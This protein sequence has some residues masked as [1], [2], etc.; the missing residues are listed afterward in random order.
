MK[1]MI[2]N[3]LLLALSL[4]LLTGCWNSREL[5]ELAIAVALG[6]DKTDHNHYVVS[7]Q[8]VNPGEISTKGGG[9][10]NRSPVSTFR[11]EGRSVFEALR[12]MTT[13]LNRKIYL[14]HLRLIV[15]G[16]DLAKEGIMV[17]MDFLSR[18]HEVRTDF[19][20]VVAK[21]TKAED[22]LEILTP[23][24]KIPASKLFSSLEMSEKNWAGTTKLTLDMLIEDL[25]SDG[26]SPV[27][28]GLFVS[29]PISKGK[30][31]ENT[32]FSEVPTVLQYDG[33]ALF[34]RDK[35]IGWLNETQT[36]GYNYAKGNV[37]STVG[38]LECPGGLAEIELIQTTSKIK[39][40]LTGG[41]NPKIEIEVHAEGNVGD[42]SCDMDMSD[43]ATI[44]KFEQLAADQI[45]ESINNAIYIAQTKYKTDVFG[46]GEV[47]H[48]SYPK[49]WKQWRHDWDSTFV[50]L[51]VETSVDV[52]IRRIGT[53]NQP[54]KT[55]V[56]K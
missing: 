8:L 31:L 7:V 56:R 48:R 17:P 33:L 3:G 4:T 24:E 43:P 14:S 47:L 44:E 16:E 2:R 38:I 19:Y 37:E 40:A 30:G 36:K 22:V 55:R 10:G 42:V 9:G 26:K 49:Q 27:L 12:K 11:M 53:I 18:D 15:F 35:L 5:N 1:S 25:E 50:D 41:G 28:T 34:K 54:I 23:L 45:A 29:G 52:A 20:I 6:F 21:G 13:E 46:F 51:N 32:Q 39:G